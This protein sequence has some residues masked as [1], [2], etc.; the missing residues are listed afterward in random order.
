MA[1]RQDQGR[2][3]EL[4]TRAQ[5]ARLQQVRHELGSWLDDHGAVP[6]VRSEIAL[7]VHEAAANVVQHAYAGGSGDLVV[8]ARVGHGEVTVVVEDAGGWRVP[9]RT[10]HRGRGLALMHGLMDDVEI[11]PVEVG[12]GTRVTLRRR[13][14]AG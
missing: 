9:G 12:S 6:E 1:P 7:A 14:D 8:R 2:E 3:F 10:D 13:V 11:S 4:R 5:A